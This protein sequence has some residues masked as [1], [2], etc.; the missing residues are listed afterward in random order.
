MKNISKR[1]AGVVALDG[2]DFDLQAG[3]VHVLLGENGAGKSTLVKIL[4]GA[5]APDT[6]AIYLEGTE[7]RFSHP[8]EALQAGIAVVYQELNLVPGLTVAQNLFLRREPVRPLLRFIDNRAMVRAAADVFDA[9][10]VSVPLRRPVAELSVA[11]R[12]MV[13][14]AKAYAQDAKVL[15]LD[16]PTSSLGEAETQRLFDLV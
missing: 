1:F 8:Q 9:L 14:I 12:Q 13:E 4:A 6:G 5:H 10:G 2:V 3:E 11:E 16:E 15:V 7:R